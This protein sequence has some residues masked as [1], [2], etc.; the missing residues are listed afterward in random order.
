MAA[1]RPR[2]SWLDGMEQRME[3]RTRGAA[4]DDDDDAMMT[5]MTGVGGG[6]SSTSLRYT[7]GVSFSPFLICTVPSA[8]PSSVVLLVA[9]AHPVSSALCPT[10]PLL[11]RLGSPAMAGAP[12]PVTVRT[13]RLKFT[14]PGIDG[15]PPPGAKPLIQD[16]SLTLR[17]GDRCLLVGANGAGFPPSSF[18]HLLFSRHLSR[19]CFSLFRNCVLL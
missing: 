3:G 4:H 2:L 16:F 11:L 14:Y 19:V 9:A 6:G 7:R 8:L 1:A 5:R 17:A 15:A 12:A 18:S 13:N 10:L